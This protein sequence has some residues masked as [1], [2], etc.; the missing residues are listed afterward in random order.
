MKQ[1]FKIFLCALL[2]FSL[3]IGYFVYDFYR[4]VKAQNENYTPNYDS[5]WYGAA[6]LED[7]GD[8]YNELIK[9][10]NKSSRVNFLLMGLEWPRTDTL[11]LAS[12]DVKTKDLNLL[13]I[14]RDTYYYKKGFRSGFTDM[15]EYKIN[16][17]FGDEGPEGVVKAVKDIF[18]IPIH[19]Y[20]TIS[21]AGVESI[22]DTLG[23][24]EVNVPYDM[25]YEDPWDDPPFVINLKKGKQVLDGDKAI[26]FLRFRKNNA[27]TIAIGDTG[28]I[29]LQQ[30][31]IQSAIKK[32]LSLK[33]PAVIKEAFNCVKTDANI[34]EILDYANSAIGMDMD[35]I[36]IS[37]V[38]GDT[39]YQNRLSYF[40]IDQ[41]K[42]NEIIYSLYDVES[43]N[44]AAN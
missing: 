20:V 27:E 34:L 31:F 6:D 36:S 29:K 7:L 25:Y 11:I 14:P 22:V 9:A 44:K 28:R 12:F 43:L 32:S 35:K 30:Q 4:D 39:F 5:N 24:V 23:G 19:H 41:S 1:F 3:F 2:L 16:A 10:I 13:S 37:T 8:S 18:N 26:Q 17:I 38:P 40:R 42:L 15:A 33:L 21:Y